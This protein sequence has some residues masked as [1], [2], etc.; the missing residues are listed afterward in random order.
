MITKQE[1]QDALTF[2]GRVVALLA[3]T[4]VDRE[5]D[6]IC[7]MPQTHP[8]YEDCAWCILKSVRLTV[9]AEMDAEESH[10]KSDLQE[11][12]W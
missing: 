3:E 1:L 9:E 10:G 4:A 6:H 2:E 8:R 12:G 5:C 7:S 11:V